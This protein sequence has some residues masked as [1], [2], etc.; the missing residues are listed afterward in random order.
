LLRE[1]VKIFQHLP[2]GAII[3]RKVLDGDD[4]QESRIQPGEKISIDIKYLNLTFLNMFTSYKEKLRLEKQPKEP[5]K[6]E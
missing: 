4:D 5:K 1:Q 3:H 6:T 2:D